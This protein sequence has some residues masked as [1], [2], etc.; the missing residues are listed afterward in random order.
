MIVPVIKFEGSDSAKQMNSIFAENLHDLLSKVDD[1]KGIFEAGFIH[2]STILHDGNCYYKS[3]WTRDAGRGII[4]L[5]RLGFYDE[6]LK[7]SRYLL[8]NINHGD[9]WGRTTK[10]EDAQDYEIDGNAL[11]LIGLF[12][13]WKINGKDKEIAKEI[14]TKV[15]PLF[16]W[17]K[18]LMESCSYGYLLPCRTEMA[19]NPNAPYCVYAI[20]PNYAMKIALKGFYEMACALGLEELSAKIKTMEEKLTDS[21]IKELTSNGKNSKTL[22]DCWINGLDGRDGRSYEFSEWDGTSWPIYHWTRQLPFVLQSDLGNLSIVKDDC[23]EINK[24]SYDYIH[25]YMCKS[26]YFRKY[27][28]VSNTGWTGTGGRHDDTMCGYGQGFMTQAAL[29]NDDINTYT[30]LLEGITRL[31]YDGDIVEPLAFDMN[32]WVMHECFNYENYEEGYDHTFGTMAE[33]R[34]GIMNCPGDEGNLVQAAEIIKAITLLAGIDDSIPGKL[35]IIPRIPWNW[36]EISVKD[37]PYVDEAGNVARIDYSM[38]HD[39]SLRSCRFTLKS[40]LSLKKIDVRIGPFPAYLN[41]FSGNEMEVEKTKG[42]SW[43][44]LRGLSG[45]LVEKEIS[46]W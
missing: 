20:Y 11:I 21:I 35:Q 5:A 4:E 6:A 13:T 8:N 17:V 30:K 37:F 45:S 12:N 44:W 25:S 31:A 38:V 15:M 41:T 7:V 24:K 43:V 27:G 3:I 2:T 23:N 39:R 42:G 29:M 33:G 26:K 36:D 40:S 19:G 34:P 16:D 28:F 14:I 9:H 10:I 32:P 22:K 46:V 1:G 18:N